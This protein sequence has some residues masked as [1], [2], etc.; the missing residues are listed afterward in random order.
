MAIIDTKVAFEGHKFSGLFVGH[1]TDRSSCMRMPTCGMDFPCTGADEWTETRYFAL[2]NE[3]T[4]FFGV[5]CTFLT[6][7][8]QKYINW[9]RMST[10]GGEAAQLL[11]GH[12]STP[13]QFRNAAPPSDL[14]FKN[15]RSPETPESSYEAYCSAA[16][17]VHGKFWELHT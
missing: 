16:K 7:R 11:H 8:F 4:E 1:W 2:E 6:R 5:I 10:G 3:Q 12:L 13:R 15:A 9:V 17:E 14:P